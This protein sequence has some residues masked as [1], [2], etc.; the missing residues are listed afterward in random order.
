MAASSDLQTKINDA[1]NSLPSE[2]R[3]AND[4]GKIDFV[5]FW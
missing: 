5:E 3:V 1:W 4:N 2:V